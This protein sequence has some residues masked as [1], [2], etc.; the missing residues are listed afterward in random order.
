MASVA[1]QNAVA[2]ACPAHQPKEKG[3][4]LATLGAFS[5]AI[6]G[7]ACCWLLLLLIAFG[8]SAAGVGSFFEQYRPHLLCATFALLAIAWYLTYRAT[9]VR[10]WARL[11]RDSVAPAAV[12][13]CCTTEAPPAATH[14]CCATELEP[15]DCCS[16][17][18]ETAVGQP[19]ALAAHDAAVQPGDA[20][21]GHGRDPAFL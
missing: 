18:A 10:A 13:A 9:L 7:S 3:A 6:L 4:F 17:R 20:L 2:E 16:R 15:V 11:R 5:T 21:D 14:S 8:F 1:N 19:A 12:E